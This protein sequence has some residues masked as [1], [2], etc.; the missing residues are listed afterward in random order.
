MKNYIILTSFLVLSALNSRSSV[1]GYEE[2][3]FSPHYQPLSSQSNQPLYPP[4]GRGEGA[5]YFSPRE[6]AV[7]SR[8]TVGVY[9]E[10]S[11]SPPYQYISSQ[12][13]QLLYSP[14]GRDERAFYFPP[15]ES[16]VVPSAPPPS[17]NP[18]VDTS[19]MRYLAS[20]LVKNSLSFGLP[21]EAPSDELYSDII[22]TL[23]NVSLQGH[24][25]GIIEHAEK[26]I[27][28]NAHADSI[29]EIL[30][31]VANIESP[32]KK[33]L[34]DLH[35]NII[36]TTIQP[37][38][39]FNMPNKERK[40]LLDAVREVD[41]AIFEQMAPHIQ[42]LTKREMPGE[43]KAQ[44]IKTCLKYGGDNV[45][46]FKELV[47]LILQFIIPSME[48]Q[49]RIRIIEQLSSIGV[50][51]TKE[52]LPYFKKF[53]MPGMSGIERVAL[54]E[55]C[56][57]L[58]DLEEPATIKK[59]SS[60]VESL[61]KNNMTAS[62][63]TTLLECCRGITRDKGLSTLEG[64]IS[65]VKGLIRD[66]A[67]AADIVKL[68][69]ASAEV[70][71]FKSFMKEVKEILTKS[72][73]VAG[74]IKI[75]ESCQT[76]IEKVDDMNHLVFLIKQ[77]KKLIQ[78]FM[79]GHE[80]AFIID[81][82]YELNE[83]KKP[84]DLEATISLAKAVI[85]QEMS[86]EDRIIL[87]NDCLGHTKKTIA[88]TQ[89]LIVPFMNARQRKEILRAVKETKLEGQKL[90]ERVNLI[91][92]YVN[93]IRKT[94]PEEERTFYI[95]HYLTNKSEVPVGNIKSTGTYIKNIPFTT[96]RLLKNM[97]SSIGYGI[98]STGGHVKNATF[99]MGRGTKKVA[100]SL[101][102]PPR[103]AYGKLKDIMARFR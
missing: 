50:P 83:M 88:L 56:K 17:Y 47:P 62:E 12:S 38:M 58:V 26:I 55:S 48:L 68:L 101:A 10:N 96:A 6:S 80:I 77:A 42:K 20:R 41:A 60:Y 63:R 2:N 72:L 44:L 43:E 69:E 98:R 76:I 14:C 24:L 32:N 21:S 70:N 37:F 84:E 46:D 71:D 90:E 40:F 59:V 81:K 89:K 34:S 52:I 4:L 54:I 79:D 35:R 93:S 5:F 53:A 82:L 36:M 64:V 49:E 29:K 99:T 8:A 94:M 61:I 51:K 31:G 85:T 19:N 33:G 9:E 92:L 3:S 74:Q 13:N 23:K 100:S 30:E 103:L 95:V 73:T 22:D 67:T 1:G 18:Q 57:F 86:V 15:N 87:V 11:F 16:A 28:P 65:W 102:T 27:C 78:P 97:L 75:I 66:D 91:K 25:T 7:N 45:K 39:N